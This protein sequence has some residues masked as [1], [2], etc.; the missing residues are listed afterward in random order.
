[1][2]T[3]EAEMEQELSAGLGEGQI[4]KFIEDDGLH[5][6]QMVGEPSLVAISGL[7]LLGSGSLAMVNWCSSA[8]DTR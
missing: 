6:G 8:P 4:T 2:T 7:G 5:A 3:M 1:V